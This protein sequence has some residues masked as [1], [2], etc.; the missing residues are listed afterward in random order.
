MIWLA[1][2]L[3]A[4]LLLLVAAV[5]YSAH[6]TRIPLFFSP[7]G[8]GLPQADVEMETRDGV[9]IRG[10]WIARPGSKRV[11]ILAHGYLMNRSELA[12]L[13]VWLWQRGYNCLLPDLRAHGKSGRAR[14]TIG[15]DEALD[16]EACLKLAKGRI[17][18]AEIVLFGSSMGAAASAFCAAE[19]PEG[20]RALVLDGPY[21]RLISATLGWWRFLGGW[22]LQ[23]LMAPT[24][25]LAVPLTGVNPFK[26]DVAA[27]LKKIGP[28]PVL[29]LH[30]S[31][32][33]LA[34]PGEA[35][36]NLAACENGRL[37]WLQGCDHAEGRWVLPEVFLGAIEEFLQEHG[38]IESGKVDA[39]IWG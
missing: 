36:R 3:S 11:A 17:E 24:V 19:Q 2:V 31:K 20:I 34:P 16:L 4:Y 18:G 10:W 1:V 28:M 5:L 38:L 26:V 8:V 33:R 23:V 30:G 7:G 21:S 39:P 27:A 25:L 12:P 37:V 35:A 14:C 15:R 6:P 22:A 29:L 9:R 13:A 32:D